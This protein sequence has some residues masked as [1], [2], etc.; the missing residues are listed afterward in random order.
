MRKIFPKFIITFVILIDFVWIMKYR[1]TL[2]LMDFAP[3]YVGVIFFKEGKFEEAYFTDKNT[4][5]SN[6]EIF[7]KELNKRGYNLD[8]TNSYGYFPFTVFLFLP[9]T[10]FSLKIG[11]LLFLVIIILIFLYALYFLKKNLNIDFP[12]SL[13]F[14]LILISTP[15]RQCA[16]TGNPEFLVVAFL[17][18]SLFFS[19]FLSGLLLSIAILIK[20][21]SIFL[22]PYFLLKKDRIKTFLCTLIFI[23]IE[24]SLSFLIFGYKVIFLYFDSLLL[25]IKGFK[26]YA[27]AYNFFHSF[28]GKDY[29]FLFY[30]F[31]FIISVLPFILLLKKHVNFLIESGIFLTVSLIFVPLFQPYY[32]LRLFPYF[33]LIFVDKN[34]LT[35]YFI[36]P[37]LFLISLIPYSIIKVFP[38]TYALSFLGIYVVSLVYINKY[39]TEKI[40]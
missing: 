10:I 39:G 26:D 19:P 25:V 13:F 9:F 20:P 4:G 22:L 34:V 23:I 27:T 35:K 21:H 31:I 15:F 1:D 11:G 36:I 5:F 30:V 7:L 40:T 18:F 3:R 24:I 2:F 29:A 6:S 14:S 12:E 28:I 16:L 37:I 8:W 32:I 17:V 33:G 38:W